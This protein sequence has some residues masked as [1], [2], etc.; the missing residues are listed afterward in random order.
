ML[1]RALID[2]GQLLDIQI[3][4]HIVIGNGN[5]VSLKERRLAFE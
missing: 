1:T 3:L 4:D 5:F 2:A